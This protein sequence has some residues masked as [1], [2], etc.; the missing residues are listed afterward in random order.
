MNSLQDML[1]FSYSML[2]SEG[3]LLTFPADEKKSTSVEFRNSSDKMM[4]VKKTQYP[5]ITDDDI[6]KLST[7]IKN[8]VTKMKTEI[9]EKYKII[10]EYAKIINGTKNE[11]QKLY[12]ENIIYRDK[13]K[14]QKEH[15]QQKYEQQTTEKEIY[16]KQ[17][18]HDKQ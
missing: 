10:N 17:R 1:S 9:K 8:F 5:K 6:S 13:L 11:Y 16:K 14:Q 18:K 2:D 12:A 15:D 4:R 7:D 3:N